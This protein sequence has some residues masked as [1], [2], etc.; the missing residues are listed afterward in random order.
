MRQRLLFRRTSRGSDA[1]RWNLD[2]DSDKCEDEPELVPADETME[3]A[4]PPQP[5]VSS[6]EGAPSEAPSSNLREKMDFMLDRK[7]GMLSTEVSMALIGLD[8]KPATRIQK[9]AES[10][11]S[12]VQATSDRID[13]AMARLEQLEMRNKGKEKDGESAKENP[14][15]WRPLHVIVGGWPE[16]SAKELAD[17]GPDF[18]EPSPPRERELGRLAD[19][20]MAGGKGSIDRLLGGHGCGDEGGGGDQP[21]G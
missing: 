21:V 12:E 10:R 18:L 11:K 3:P 9:E 13:V 5:A 6:G 1:K 2:R 16:R 7:S 17:H 20:F 4:A 14:T 8:C 19:P 15:A